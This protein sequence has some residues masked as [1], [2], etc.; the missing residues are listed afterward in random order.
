MSFLSPAFI[1]RCFLALCAGGACVGGVSACASEGKVP[2]VDLG[3]PEV[4]WKAKNDEQRLG[5]MA[6][7]VQPQ[8]EA[9]FVKH[10]KSYAKN[11]FTCETC[12]GAKGELIDWKMPNPDIYALPK[13][14]TLEAS[15]EYDEDV[16]KFMA[17]DVTPAL[18]KMLNAGHGGSTQTS[19]FS[20]HPAE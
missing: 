13:E 20:C 14:N 5:F 18:E 10:D 2:G 9:L 8:M 4:S 17:E 1:R 15:K 6:A 16:T 3:S 19:C 11:G 7:A 12:H